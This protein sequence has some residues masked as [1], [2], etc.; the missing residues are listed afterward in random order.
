MPPLAIRFESLTPHSHFQFT[1]AKIKA[2]TEIPL[3]RQHIPVCV[4]MADRNLES[5]AIRVLIQRDE[6]RVTFEVSAALWN[7]DEAGINQDE[8]YEALSTL[9]EIPNGNTWS[10]FQHFPWRELGSC[11]PT[12]LWKAKQFSIVLDVKC[13][14]DKHFPPPLKKMIQPVQRT[15]LGCLCKV[16]GFCWQCA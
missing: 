16:A 3:S 1:L 6:P 13:F 12:Y 4:W 8:G 14:P 10:V 2:A 9:H 7:K 5:P 11:I 15:T